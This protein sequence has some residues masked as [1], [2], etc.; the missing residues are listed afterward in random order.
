M[1]RNDIVQERLLVQT[2]TRYSVECFWIFQLISLA[3]V[4]EEVGIGYMARALVEC[5]WYCMNGWI[6]GWMD[7]W[8]D[9]LMDG[10]MDGC[11]DG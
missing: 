9:G 10:W 3:A 2:L 5:T 6:D 4:G 8:M 7:G 11:M 1:A